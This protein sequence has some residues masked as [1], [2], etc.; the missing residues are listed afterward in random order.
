MISGEVT[1][2]LEATLSLTVFGPD[3]QSE[4]LDAIIDTGFTGFLTLPT[5]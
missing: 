1:D 3:D 5:G 4:S 2:L